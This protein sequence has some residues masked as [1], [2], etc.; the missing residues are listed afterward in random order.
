MSLSTQRF[1]SD[2]FRDMQRAM[3]MFDHP[4]FN[5]T[6]RSLLGS[7]AAL[8]K[9]SGAGHH[10]DYS[11]FGHYPPT[12]IVETSDAY[13]LSAELPGFDKKNIKIE[14]ADNQ[15]LVLSGSVKAISESNNPNTTTTATMDTTTPATASN[16]NSL[17]QEKLSNHDESD[18]KI[19]NETTPQWRVKERITESFSRSFAFPT[20]IIADQIKASFENGILKVTVTKP[21]QE[22]A[23]QIHID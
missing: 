18:V 9:N 3:T 5:S 12:D 20:P 6:R 16:S 22:Q 23:K 8:F 4:F 10:L 2:A 17:E 19:T 21:V 7:P 13:E 14:L 1:F 15:T 11:L